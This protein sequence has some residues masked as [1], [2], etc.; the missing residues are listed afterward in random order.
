MPENK[1]VSLEFHIKH[2]HKPKMTEKK[3][4]K[5]VNFTQNPSSPKLT[6]LKFHRK[7]N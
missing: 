7:S 1:W 2:R 3:R 4:K 5:E 6:N